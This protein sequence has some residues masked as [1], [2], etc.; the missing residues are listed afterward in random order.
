MLQ[1]GLKPRS[2]QTCPGQGKDAAPVAAGCLFR[3]ELGRESGHKSQ[4]SSQRQLIEGKP[5]IQLFLEE[6]ETKQ[7][8]S[9]LSC[10]RLGHGGKTKMAFCS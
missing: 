3:R 7:S 2:A 8:S 10:A 1:R 9:L 5:N 6:L 4:V